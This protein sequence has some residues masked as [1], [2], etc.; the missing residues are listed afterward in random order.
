MKNQR[1]R[2]LVGLWSMGWFLQTALLWAHEGHDHSEAPRKAA[3]PAAAAT[4]SFFDQLSGS[5]GGAG[6]LAVIALIVGVVGVLLVV[7]FGSRR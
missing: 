7:A 1:K 4:S 3:A 6:M 2:L 5:V